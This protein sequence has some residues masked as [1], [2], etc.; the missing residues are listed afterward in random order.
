MSTGRTLTTRVHSTLRVVIRG[1]PLGEGAKCKVAGHDLLVL[2]RARPAEW[3]DAELVKG[4][5]EAVVWTRPEDADA[6]ADALLTDPRVISVRLEAAP[7][8]VG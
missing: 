3:P 1:F 7:V 8:D 2:S 4:D 5:L 6:A